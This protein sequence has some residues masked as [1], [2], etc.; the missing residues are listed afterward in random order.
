MLNDHTHTHTHMH[1]YKY[2]R[3]ISSKKWKMEDKIIV[4]H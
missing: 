4:R 3:N 2:L 1:V